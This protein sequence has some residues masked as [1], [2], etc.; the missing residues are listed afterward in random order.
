MKRIWRWIAGIV[1][2][3]VVVAAVVF[4]GYVPR[5]YDAKNLVI[6]HKP[7][8]VSARAQVLHA[9][10]RVADLHADPLMWKRDIVKRNTSG[11]DWTSRASIEGGYALQVFSA[12]TK[13]TVGT[14]YFRVN[15]D[16]GRG[17]G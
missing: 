5:Y 6:P 11:S 15:A 16:G 2:A 3:I 9:E 4:F 10:L 1:L 13:S 7:Y 14:G 12:V 8:V 17:Q